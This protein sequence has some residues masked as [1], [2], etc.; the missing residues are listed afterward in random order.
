MKI[1]VL[2]GFVICLT[3]CMLAMD[4]TPE[5]QKGKLHGRL[6]NMDEKNTDAFQEQ[7]FVLPSVV[8]T[9]SDPVQ[10]PAEPY[11]LKIDPVYSVED[12]GNQR[13]ERRIEFDHGEDRFAVVYP[14]GEYINGMRVTA[15]KIGPSINYVKRSEEKKAVRKKMAIK[16]LLN[17]PDLNL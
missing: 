15:K 8:H 9:P 17:Q 16:Y 5:T 12:G 2:A 14:A 4:N 6:T 1:I 13:V 11:N 10:A 7:Y 3:N